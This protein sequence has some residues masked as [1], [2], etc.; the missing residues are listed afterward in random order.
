MPA[1]PRILVMLADPIVA[2]NPALLAMANSR[3]HCTACALLAEKRVVNR[4]MGAGSW[5]SKARVESNGE[6]DSGMILFVFSTVRTG[7][8]KLKPENIAWI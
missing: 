5:M 3:T 8:A 1:T 6:K 7:G 4:N 2:F